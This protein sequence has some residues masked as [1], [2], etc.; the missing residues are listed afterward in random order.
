MKFFGK[1]NK[2]GFS[3]ILV[4]ALLMQIVLPMSLS[5]ADTG[6]IGDI[7]TGVTLKVDGVEITQESFIEIKDET[8]VELDFKWAIDDEVNVSS[9]DWAEIS[10]PPALAFLRSESGPLIGP[11]YDLD[12]NPDIV[13]TYTLNM[14]DETLKVVFNDKLQDKNEKQGFV[15]FQVQF[16]LTEFETN[17]TQVI[18]FDEPINKEFVITLKPQGDLSAI[19]KL[20]KPDAEINATNINW[21]IDVNTELGKI[22]NAIL[23]DKIPA[24]LDLNAGSIEVYHLAVGYSGA[25]TLGSKVEGIT[26]EITTNPDGFTIITIT[27]GEIDSAYRIKYTT[28]ITD[29]SKPSYI[30]AAELF[31]AAESLGTASSTVNKIVKGSSIEKSGKADTKDAVDATRITWTIDINKSESAIKN[32]KVTDV[33]GPKLEQAE[34]ITIVELV[35]SGSNWSIG[36]DKTEYF[37]ELN[38]GT[39]AFPLSLGDISGAY[40]IVFDSKIAYGADYEK[41]VKLENTAALEGDNIDKGEIKADVTVTRSSLLEK[42]GTPTVNY[43]TKE[44]KW[45]VHVN[46]AKHAI[47]NAVIQDSFGVGH[48]L[49]PGTLKVLDSTGKAVTPDESGFPKITE[50]PDKKGF[51]VELGTI[52]SY[53]KLE[54]ATVITDYSQKTYT[55]G[56]SL[57]G[58]GIGDGVTVNPGKEVTIAN[59][60]TKSADL[61]GT[62]G[63][64][65]Y[66]GLNYNAKTMS[67]KVVIKPTKEKI[68]DLTVTD[69][70]PNKGLLFLPD[71]L[72]VIKGTGSTAVVLTKGIHYTVEPRT[73]D[74]VVPNTNGY[75]NGFVLKFLGG[76]EGALPLENSDYSIYYKT[77]F[78]PDLVLGA[79]GKLNTTNVY[80]NKVAFSGETENASGTKTPIIGDSSA[81]YTVIDNAYNSGKKEGDLRRADREIDWRVYVNYMSQNLKTADF[82]VTD[83]LSEGQEFDESTLVVK[84]YT[85]AANGTIQEEDT[86]L[87]KDTHYTVEKTANG[88]KLTFP[89]G[90]DKPYVVKYTAKIMGISKATYTNEAIVTGGGKYTASVTYTDHDKFLVKE[91]VNVEN[92]RVYT[93]DIINWRVTLNQSLSEIEKAVFTDTI[94]SGLVYVND[95]LKVY[96]EQGEDKELA[97]KEQYTLD[98]QLLDNGD[99]KLTVTFN[100]KINAVYIIEYDTVVIATAGKVKNNAVFSGDKLE[101]IPGQTKEYS[102]T[103]TSSGTGS[104]VNKGKIRIVKV[105]GENTDTKLNAEFELY[106]LLNGEK[107]IIGDEKKATVDGVLEYTNLSLRTYYLREVTASEGYQLPS[108]AMEITLT[109][110]NK[111]VVQTVENFKLGSLAIQKVDGKD[112]EKLLEGAEFTLI[113]VA[114]S[115]ENILKTDVN[116]E[117]G[118]DKLPHGEYKLKETKAPA[119]YVLDRT[120][121]TIVIDNDHTAVALKLTNSKKTPSGPKDEYGSI[122]IQKVDSKDETKGLA[123]AVFEVRD[124]EGKIAATLTT[125]ENGSA[126]VNKLPFGKYIIIEIKAPAGYLLNSAEREVDLSDDDSVVELKHINEK[127]PTKPNEPKNPDESIDPQGPNG[128]GSPNETIDHG[129]TLPKTGEAGNMIYYL[130]GLLIVIVGMALKK[131]ESN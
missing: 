130:A 111:I 30:N 26:P 5:Y 94:A 6:N 129:G 101:T 42:T 70:F 37:K 61:T 102:A 73:D 97:D 121:R 107:R 51:K 125:D 56:V 72:K 85:V 116:G 20:G 57:G 103:Q 92:N 24:G 89:G 21:E 14:A 124:A 1:K 88:F 109:S 10:L 16:D 60:Y 84:E 9:G 112:S 39:L 127:S 12:G 54:Y 48:E 29:Y 90:I 4:W 58:G 31:N 98:N 62:F 114:T 131:K 59:S 53:Y 2:K 40:R 25:K 115:V 49:K 66:D 47:T 126:K 3:I 77:S 105:D 104:G 78:N 44:V 63:G 123:G 46:K 83:T 81:S 17:T 80:A 52:D 45:T 87:V 38:K 22:T 75:Q 41:T 118:V 99:R 106:Y 68:T 50:N 120:E 108:E 36:A 86:V 128:P 43:D 8:K 93:D 95:S 15:N 7:F 65:T 11:D 82:V 32:A 67:W 91:G 64:I 34:N 110:A 69:T 119:G 113:N 71:T 117:A 122:T 96:Q 55:N 13:G 76:A 33:L 18:H 19:S 74:T 79:G 28:K 27:L 35:K 100:N 23:K